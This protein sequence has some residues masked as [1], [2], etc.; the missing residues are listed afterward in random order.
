MS[1]K[2]ALVYDKELVKYDFGAFHPLRPER[3][4]L[5]VELIKSL[6]LLNRSSSELHA[7]RLATPEE[8][9]LF[10][11]HEYVREVQEASEKGQ[12]RFDLGDTPVF[13]GCFEISSL[14][15]GAT[16]RAIDLV[17]NEGCE[18]SFSPGGGLHHA[19]KD[20]ASGFC[21]FNDAAIGV[22]YLKAR[23]AVKRI[24]YVDID[25]HHGDGV[26]YGFYSDPS[27]LDVDFHEDG[28]YIFPGTGRVSEVG[29]GTAKGLKINVPLPPRTS[30]ETFLYAFSGLVPKLAAKFEPEFIVLQSGADAH[31]DDGLAHLNLTTKAYEEVTSLIHGLAHKYCQGRLVTLGGGGYN[32]SN[33]SRC[34]SIVYCVLTQSHCVEQITESWRS[35]FTSLSGDLPPST[36]HDR[37]SEPQER[38][39]VAENVLEMVN[40]I[41]MIIDG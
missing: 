23:Y 17:M 19:H 4:P 13:K 8:I 34:W 29:E 24:M 14:V 41:N 30:D 3:L 22:A 38:N 21:I 1:G 20:R 5:T 28:Q 32:L 25:A 31:E 36:L 33:T 9:M 15:A 39:E 35:Y 11:T 10:H 27:V 16:L 40:Q 18:H 7:P 37:T 12:G 26:M 6:N 2:S